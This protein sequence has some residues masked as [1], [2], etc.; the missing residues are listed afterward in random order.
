MNAI[1]LNSSI[2]TLHGAVEIDPKLV[3]YFLFLLPKM[4]ASRGEIYLLSDYILE[5][6]E[7]PGCIFS[8]VLV[9]KECRAQISANVV[10]GCTN[11]SKRDFW[12]SFFVQ[13]YDVLGN[14]LQSIPTKLSAHCY[15]KGENIS[16]LQT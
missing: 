4:S 9:A 5:R 11:A 14:A 15:G 3:E 1:F 13:H 12:K 8:Q 7:L 2:V 16:L 6:A 10:I